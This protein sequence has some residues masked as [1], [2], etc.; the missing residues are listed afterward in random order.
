MGKT[1]ENGKLVVA[2]L[3]FFFRA[4][5]STFEMRELPHSCGSGICRL[6][7][8]NKYLDIMFV[9]TRGFRLA[10]IE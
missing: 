9:A 1:V 4:V 10:C 3:S 2:G 7:F 5:L 8:Q 6:A